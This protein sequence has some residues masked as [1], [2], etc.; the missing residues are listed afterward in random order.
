MNKLFVSLASVLLAL[1]CT[2]SIS[3]SAPDV[4]PEDPAGNGL[5]VFEAGF[6][7][8]PT[9]TYVDSDMHLHW[10]ADDRLS[11]FFKNTSNLQYR[12]SGNTGDVSGSFKAVDGS[13]PTGDALETNYAVYPYS[14]TTSITEGGVITLTLPAVEAY[15]ENSFGVDA[16]TMVAVTKS[17]SSFFLPFKNV[18]GYLTFKFYGIGTVSSIA[19]S[20][21][22]GEK[23]AGVATVTA[24]YGEAPSL[25]L[26]EE[27]ATGMV[28]LDCGEGV[29]L[30]ETSETA[31]VFW[32]VIP[33]V[34]FSKGFSV[35]VTDINGAS[36]TFKTTK[37][38]V[39]QRSSVSRMAGLAIDFSTTPPTFDNNGIDALE[40]DE[41]EW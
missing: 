21:N 39:I 38:R 9:R 11:I 4:S 32:F 14:A 41:F 1:G 10:T 26:H 40:E 36:A 3:D 31:T 33:Q 24:E 16:N 35:T 28:T 5:P 12:F 2:S 23:I 8:M 13:T 15:G 30:G 37:E 22:D 7:S 17:P 18:C 25:S 29:T 20:G 34:T 19:L 27:T 6:E